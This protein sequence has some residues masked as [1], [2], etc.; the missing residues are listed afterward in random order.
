MDNFLAIALVGVAVSLLIEG[1]N[2]WLG[3]DSMKAK[4][5]TLAMAVFA[6]GIYVAFKDTSIWQTMLEVLMASSTVYAF[7]LKSKK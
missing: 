7:F 2:K 1:I 6:G 4:W 5:L 3:F